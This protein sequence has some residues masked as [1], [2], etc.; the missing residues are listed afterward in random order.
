MGV[1]NSK[2]FHIGHSV[3]KKLIKF[4]KNS[5]DES[6]KMN[7]KYI[8][9]VVDIIKN[10]KDLS[11]TEDYK[12]YRLI[13]GQQLRRISK[14]G[15]PHTGIYIYNGLIL[16]MGSGPKKCSKKI[17]KIH[18]ITQNLNGLSTLKQFKYNSKYM[19][20]IITDN[21]L[22][23]KTTIKRLKRALKIVGKQNYNYLT[24]NCFHMANYISHGSK[25]LINIKNLK[26]R[27]IK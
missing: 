23:N 17:G 9:G 18:E 27:S 13:P 15:I 11:K 7:K 19:N 1:N 21:D 25:K 4:N 12:K 2:P 20:V 24:D 26:R 3:S 5:C 6:I 16:E 14:R 22:N 8:K 10:T